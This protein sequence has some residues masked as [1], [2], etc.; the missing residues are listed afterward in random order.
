L[1][2]HAVLPDGAPAPEAAVVLSGARLWPA[3]KTVTNAAGIATITG[4][5]DGAYDLS[6]TLG[7]QVSQTLFGFSLAEG[8]HD[9]V[10]LMLGPGRTVRVSVVDGEEA[11]A[12][13]VPDADVVLVEGGLGS[14]PFRGRTDARGEVSLGP[15]PI[16][17]AVVSARASGFVARS[18]VQVPPGAGSVRVGLLGG[19]TLTG[20]VVAAGGYPI[21]G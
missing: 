9:E 7:T 16:G 17:P 6:A 19:G 18:G 14:F 13:P 12:A 15:L 5:L 2:V 8:R 10:T 4:L 20:A 1:A 3:R 11:Q 21:I